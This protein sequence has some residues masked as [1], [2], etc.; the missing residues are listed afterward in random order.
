MHNLRICGLTGMCVAF[1]TARPCRVPH[2]TISDIGLIVGS[3]VK[4]VSRLSWQQAFA[5]PSQGI[6]TRGTFFT[7]RYAYRGGVAGPPRGP[8]PGGAVYMPASRPGGLTPDD[9]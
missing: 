7:N 6:V 5:I 4:N 8:V 9:R 3:L 2:H 1:L